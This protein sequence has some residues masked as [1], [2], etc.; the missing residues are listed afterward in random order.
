MR[1]LMNGH[2]TR[3]CL[4][5][6]VSSVERALDHSDTDAAVTGS[7]L[8]RLQGCSTDSPLSTGENPARSVHFQ[9]RTGLVVSCRCFSP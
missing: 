7:P 3:P 1:F 4:R 9:C 5:E 8:K 6:A 2:L